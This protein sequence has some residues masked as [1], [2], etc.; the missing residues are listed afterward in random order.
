MK[1]TLI[2]V[3]AAILVTSPTWAAPLHVTTP[4]DV[5]ARPY[6]ARGIALTNKGQY[7]QAIF[8]FDKALELSP[9]Y[10]AAY[11]NRGIARL[12]M[13][14]HDRAIA[15]ALPPWRNQLWH[16]RAKKWKGSSLIYSSDSALVTELKEI[17]HT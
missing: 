5:Q 17:L 11:Y 6:N 12:R 8:E 4:A 9:V 16:I 1:Q 15:D 2:L 10:A 13:H 3:P 7:E 14:Q